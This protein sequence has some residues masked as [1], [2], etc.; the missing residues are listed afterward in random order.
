MSAT[1]AAPPAGRA[2]RRRAPLPPSP[3]V[4]ICV[5]NEGLGFCQGCGRTPADVAQWPEASDAQKSAIWRQLPG[6]LVRLGVKA[7]R[8]PAAPDTVN[9][10][11]QRSLRDGAGR[12]EF[13]LEGGA[14]VFDATAACDIEEIS[15]GLTARNADGDVMVFQP[16]DRVRAFGLAAEAGSGGMAA[17]ALALPRGRAEISAAAPD[18]ATSRPDGHIDVDYPF[19]HFRAL[20]GGTV[21]RAT[22]VLGYVQSPATPELFAR[23]QAFRYDETA[24]GQY[25]VAK[26][27]AVCAVFRAADRDWLKRAI[28]P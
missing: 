21:L 3:C 8:L 10:F 26:S 4:G 16:S 11:V 28:A 22:T 15:T 18:G 24:A 5:V 9:A 13:G 14:A 25:A 12:W 1:G 17:V 7:F 19:A 27:F 2:R 20:D 23:L 6:R